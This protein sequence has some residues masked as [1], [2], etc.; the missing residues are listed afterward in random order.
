MAQLNIGLGLGFSSISVPDLELEESE[1][2]FNKVEISWFGKNWIN[3]KHWVVKFLWNKMYKLLFKNVIICIFAVAILC[4]GQIVGALISA[5]IASYF[6][7][8][9]AVLIS[10]PLGLMGWILQVIKSIHNDCISWRKILRQN[11]SE[12]YTNIFIPISLRV[13]ERTWKLWWLEDSFL[14]CL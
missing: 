13:L 11:N 12:K 2:H 8:K 10:C 7:R 4:I 14:G 5:I 6:G 9:P 3:Y 1:I